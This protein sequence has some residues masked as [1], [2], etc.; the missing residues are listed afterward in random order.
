MNSG[1]HGHSS[2][3][4]FCWQKALGN[5]LATVGYDAQLAATSLETYIQGGQ[6]AQGNYLAILGYDDQLHC[7]FYSYSNSVHL[8]CA[9]YKFIQ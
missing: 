3:V 2:P 9:P 7:D 8:Q 5:Y 1:S 4:Y 6:K